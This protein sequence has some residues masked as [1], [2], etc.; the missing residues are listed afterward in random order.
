MG[1]ATGQMTAETRAALTERKWKS[2]GVV[3]YERQRGR[4]KKKWII[5]SVPGIKD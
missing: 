3:G 5:E 2:E 1:I 4:L